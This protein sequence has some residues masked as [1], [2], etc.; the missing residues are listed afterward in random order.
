M[1]TIKTVILAMLAAS[2]LTSCKD[3]FIE[4]PEVT[5]MDLDDVF[6]TA[7]NAEGAI[8]EAYGSILSSG[9]PILDWNNSPIM[10]YETTEAIMGG[11]DLDRMNWGYMDKQVVA[12]MLAN[13]ENNGAGYTDDYF[14]NNYT[15]I[16]K[17]WLVYE[18]ID[19]V[20]DMGTRDKD[21]VKAEMQTLVVI[22]D[23]EYRI[24]RYGQ[25]YGWG[26][27][28]YATPE[29]LFKPARLHAATC[30]DPDV[31]LDRVC[32]HLSYYLPDADL[33]LLPKLIDY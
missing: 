5:G 27:A 28:R 18:N 13:N 8:A 31:S 14:P 33:S 24:D 10:P 19:K 30:F 4:K 17:A 2:V 23:F 6:S 32:R 15:F 22:A 16:R 3:F 9:L 1:K 12:G 20:A 29:V 7:K 26:V 25:P 11:E 21:I